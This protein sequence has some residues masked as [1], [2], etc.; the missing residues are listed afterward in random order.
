MRPPPVPEPARVVDASEMAD[1]YPSIRAGS[2]TSDPDGNVWILP[3]T[4]VNAAGGLTYDLVNAKGVLVERVQ[5]PPQRR[6]LA[7]GAHGV[8]YMLNAT[9]G[10]PTRERARIVRQ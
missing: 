9:G 1:Y 10:K 6:L 4:S 5:L 8:V 2:V 7:L 3:T